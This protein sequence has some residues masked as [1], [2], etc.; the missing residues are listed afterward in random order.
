MKPKMFEELLDSVRG[1]RSDSPWPE[2][3][4]APVRSWALRNSGDSRT[5]RPVTVGVCE[6]DWRQRENPAELR[7]GPPPSNRAGRSSLEDHRARAPAGGEGDSSGVTSGSP[8]ATWF[9]AFTSGVPAFRSRPDRTMPRASLDQN[10]NRMQPSSHP[11][12][13]APTDRVAGSH[14][15][16][17]FRRWSRRRCCIEPHRFRQGTQSNA[18]LGPASPLSNGGNR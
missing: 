1:R 4:L 18:T 8:M 13:Q 11:L 5:N 16:T 7:A 15:A 2:E 3:T 12:H 14:T 17:S 10:S 9:R 6:A